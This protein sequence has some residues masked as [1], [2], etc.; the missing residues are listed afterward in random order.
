MMPPFSLYVRLLRSLPCRPVSGVLRDDAIE[1]VDPGDMLEL[2]EHGFF[3]KG[4]VSRRV[5]N[6]GAFEVLFAAE[7]VEAERQIAEAAEAA[8]KAAESGEGAISGASE[9]L[10]SRPPATKRAR[11]EKNESATEDGEKD[12]KTSP[13]SAALD[14]LVSSL[15]S[16]MTE[17]VV[18]TDQMCIAASRSLDP[19]ADVLTKI[20]ADFEARISKAPLPEA[21]SAAAIAASHAQDEMSFEEARAVSHYVSC[22]PPRTREASAALRD[23]IAASASAAP[24][25][26]TEASTSASAEAGGSAPD[27]SSSGAAAP[28]PPPISAPKLVVFGKGAPEGSKAIMGPAAATAAAAAAASSSSSSANK[29]QETSIL[30]PEAAMFLLLHGPPGALNITISSK[31]KQ[32]YQ[33]ILGIKLE[34]EEGATSSSSSSLSSPL[35]AKQFWLICC[36]RIGNFPARYCVYQH[37]RL[38]GW[39]VREGTIFGSDF[40][41]YSKGPGWDHAPHCITVT[42]LRLRVAAAAAATTIEGK[43]GR[44]TNTSGSNA[45]APS[46]FPSP[47]PLIR[48]PPRA[49]LSDWTEVHAVGRVVNNVKKH[50]VAAYVTFKLPPSSFTAASLASLMAATTEGG[51]AEDERRPYYYY[52][53]AIAQ[54]LSDPSVCL[55]RMTI[56]AQLF[57]RWHMTSDMSKKANAMMARAALAVTRAQEEA[58][59]AEAA[60]GEESG[61]LGGGGG[62]GEEGEDGAPNEDKGA[63]TAAS[64]V[65]HIDLGLLEGHRTPASSSASG[66][67]HSAGANSAG[68]AVVVMNKQAVRHRVRQLLAAQQQQQQQQQLQLQSSKADRAGNDAKKGGMGSS[69]GGSSG[70]A[71]AVVVKPSLWLPSG[72]ESEE[73]RVL[74]QDLVLYERILFALQHPSAADAAAGAASGAVP[75]HLAAA[76]QS[77]VASSEAARAAAEVSIG[78]HFS[79]LGTSSDEAADIAIA[80]KALARMD[81]LSLPV[82]DPA[83]Y[84]PSPILGVVFSAN[85]PQAPSGWGFPGLDSSPPPGPIPQPAALQLYQVHHALRSRFL[86]ASLQPASASFSELV[87]KAKQGLSTAAATASSLVASNATGKEVTEVEI[88]SV[89]DGASTTRGGASGAH[90]RWYVRSADWTKVKAGPAF[91]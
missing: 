70:T 15:A 85:K 20:A 16:K 18:V 14:A 54:L 34:E 89:A 71:V 66:G 13:D 25:S 5:P 45:I 69:A 33:G 4:T 49:I 90:G 60:A 63:K 36:A 41:L 39:V 10:D 53:P 11:L 24:S 12:R 84:Q 30:E 62:G 74:A 47:S 44:E 43:E 2:Y 37:Y 61:G 19:R 9:P 79:A 91:C 82:S 59:A 40:V 52:P 38:G 7:D 81:C 17:S 51:S 67:A 56:Q 73:N 48:A 23:S 21:F 77:L 57:S 78:A 35:T 76:W 87:H 64:L 80:A 88:A 32:K 58:E 26:S 83:L 3:G 68:G 6:R 75:T 28:L 86:A 65:K 46:P 8:V 42:P 29:L 22:P 27:A 31:Q 1:I 50:N 72:A 55:P